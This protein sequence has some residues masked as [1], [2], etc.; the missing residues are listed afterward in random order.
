MTF[1]EVKHKSSFSEV[2]HNSNSKDVKEK[3]I[4]YF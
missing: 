3:D 2:N 1:F 4:S